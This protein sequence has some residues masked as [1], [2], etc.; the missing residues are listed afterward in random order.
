MNTDMQALEDLISRAVAV[1]VF[2]SK[3]EA[4]RAIERWI[5]EMERKLVYE[6]MRNEDA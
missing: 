3:E 1:G 2:T 4:V 5:E 6:T